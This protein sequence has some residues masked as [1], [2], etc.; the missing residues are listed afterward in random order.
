[1]INVIDCF[2]MNSWITSQN[3][4]IRNTQ[5]ISTFLLILLFKEYTVFTCRNET[6]G[7]VKMYFL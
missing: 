2:L 4:V 5:I 1:M 3:D 6:L 7:A